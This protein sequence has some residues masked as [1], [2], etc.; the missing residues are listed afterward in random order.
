MSDHGR[1][2]R[3]VLRFLQELGDPAGAEGAGALEG[4]LRRHCT[5]DVAFEAFHPVNTLSGVSEAARGLWEPLAAAFPDLEHRVNLVIGG[6]YG[7]RDWVSTLGH[8]MGTFDQPWLGIPPTHGLAFLR[9]GMNAAVRDGRIDLAYVL[10]DAVDL[11]RQAGWYPLRRMPGTAEQWPAPPCTAA[12]DPHSHDPHTGARTLDLVLDMQAGLDS[13]RHSRHWH[14]TMN[15]YGPAGIGSARRQRGYEQYHAGL[16]DHAFPDVG[17]PVDQPGHYLRAGDGHL[18][19]TGG[20]PSLQGT[21]T[22]G[23][24]LG[25]PP[26][27]Q[28]VQ[29]RVADWYRTNPHDKIIDN[30]VAIDV[31]HILAQMGLDLFDDLRYFV[32]PTLPRWPHLPTETAAQP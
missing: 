5:E 18:A 14:P 22:G 6:S 9:F 25:L 8:L 24:W 13:G 21:H 15:W 11:M 16:F 31:P 29:M 2:K 30:W 7:D 32:D 28:Q 26:T 19:V 1:D 3:L 12:E 17:D 27:G 10:F 4:V 23:G 20:W